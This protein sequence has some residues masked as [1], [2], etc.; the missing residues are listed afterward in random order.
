MDRS[1]GERPSRRRILKAAVL[2]AGAAAIPAA[3]RHAE[4]QAKTSKA[5]AQY[6]DRPKNGQRCSGCTHFIA[7]GQCRIVEGAIDPNGWCALYASKS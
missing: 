2:L 1:N 6:Q 4:A 7:P 3:V 5:Q